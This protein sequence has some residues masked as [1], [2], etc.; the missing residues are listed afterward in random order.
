MTNAL[1]FLALVALSA[2][3]FAAC[4]EGD[5]KAE[6]G[7][8]GWGTPER[9]DSEGRVHEPSPGLA[10]SPDGSA[11][12]V[13]TSWT[14]DTNTAIWTNRYTPARGWGASERIQ[15]TSEGYVDYYNPPGVAIAANGRAIIFWHEDQPGAVWASHFTPGSGW[16]QAEQVD[17]GSP[18][19]YH[20]FW[21]DVG[22]DANGNAMALWQRSLDG[23]TVVAS[24]YIPG[25]G[26]GPIERVDDDNS[27]DPY[28]PTVAVAGNGT[29]LAIWTATIHGEQHTRILANHYTPS[30]GWETPEPIDDHDPGANPP[31][32]LQLAMDGSGN[33]T[34]VWLQH[35]HIELRSYLVTA[36]RYTPTGGW[37]TAAPIEERYDAY[38]REPHVSMN[39]KGTA[40][41]VWLRSGMSNQEDPGVWSIRYTPSTGWGI[42]ELVEADPYGLYEAYPHV[43]VDP[44]DNALIA[45]TAY[46]SRGEVVRSGHYTPTDG[47]DRSVRLD[48]AVGSCSPAQVGVDDSGKGIAVWNQSTA[49]NSR[50]YG[51][52]YGDDP[53]PDH[54][55]VWRAIC[56][57]TCG[58]ASECALL[59]EQTLAECTSECRDAG[60]HRA[61]HPNQGAI[62]A[63]IDEV[64]ALSCSDLETGWLPYVCEHICV[65]NMLC[66]ADGWEHCDDQSECTDDICD[67][68]DGSCTNPQVDD[69]APCNDGAGACQQ[70]VCTAQRGRL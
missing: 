19:G 27:R 25:T 16:S 43:A 49:S 1:R 38:S 14:E 70:G 13:W 29:A 69:G 44:Y 54:S 22:M 57:A 52:L 4:A 47:W 10:V 66:E 58:R 68:R 5:K 30:G 46:E 59:G 51:S 21:S 55:A 65:G 50:M 61:C 48:V 67:P 11:V 28:Q 45:W 17:R 23:A 33:G 8:Y 36:N 34:A 24:R 7:D 15:T 12:A 3:G 9:I 40:M 42:E 56:D 62:D 26:W 20:V 31:E 63:C 41:V 32:Q 60:S 18:D 37:E 6:P 35:Y 64:G 53:A 39:A 2:L